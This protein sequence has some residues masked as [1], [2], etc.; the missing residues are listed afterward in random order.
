MVIYIIFGRDSRHWLTEVKYSPNGKSFAV[1][2]MDH[3]IYIYN[4]ETLRLKG[5]CDRHNSYIQG[6]DFSVDS[7]YIQSDSG[8]YEHL[9]F[10][11]E[12]GEYF[13][14]ASQLKDIKWADWTCTFGWPVQ[15]D[16]PFIFVLSINSI[17]VVGAWPHFSEVESGT[18]AEPVCVHRSPNEKFLAV[19]DKKGMVKIYP[20]P[21]IRKEVS[22]MNLVLSFGSKFFAINV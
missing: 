12:D 11:A 8:D 3:K 9:Y 6:F 16:T 1:A 17:A 14:A 4:R 22:S 13:S 18:A 10:E 20:Y 15:G 2:S 5:S 21:C 7:M 19:G